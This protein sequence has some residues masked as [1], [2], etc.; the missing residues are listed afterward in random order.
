MILSLP[1]WIDAQKFLLHAWFY[2]HIYVDADKGFRMTVWLD[3]NSLV[4]FFMV[5]FCLSRLKK[6]QYSCLIVV[7]SVRKLTS[8]LAGIS[9]LQSSLFSFV[10]CGHT[11]SG[12]IEIRTCHFGKKPLK[13]DVLTKAPDFDC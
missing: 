5:S 3:Y 8:F 2:M 4:S 9:L 1:S 13:C 6:A 11:E 10:L 7:S 12:R